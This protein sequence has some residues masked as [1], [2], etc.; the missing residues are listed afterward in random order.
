MT[1]STELP[2]LYDEGQLILVPEIILWVRDRTLSKRT[3]SEYLVQ[4]KDLPSEDATWEGEQVLQQM[5]LKFIED[6]KI[7]VGRTIIYPP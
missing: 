4:W 5:I 7:W 3:I 1:I 2:P 6:K